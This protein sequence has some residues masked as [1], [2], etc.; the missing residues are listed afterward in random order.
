MD[1]VRSSVRR[2]VLHEMYAVKKT[3]MIDYLRGT[4]LLRMEQRERER[5]RKEICDGKSLACLTI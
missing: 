1:C 2:N 3:R 5:E 4:W